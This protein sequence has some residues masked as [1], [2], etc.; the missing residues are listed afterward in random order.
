MA[1]RKFTRIVCSLPVL[2]ELPMAPFATNSRG[3]AVPPGFTLKW[4]VSPRARV[5]DDLLSRAIAS[6]VP[7]PALLAEAQL[8]VEELI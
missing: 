8:W 5:V 3:L 2:G 7:S 4:D 6:D 1:R